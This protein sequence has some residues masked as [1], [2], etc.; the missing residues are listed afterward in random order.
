MTRNYIVATHDNP[1]A[2]EYYL[3][4]NPE[5]EH[6]VLPRLNHSYTVITKLEVLDGD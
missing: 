4:S 2:L 3:N 6:T 5:G 1:Q